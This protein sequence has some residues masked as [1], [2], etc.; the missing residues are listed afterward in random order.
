MHR[1][2][3]S[4][5]SNLLYRCIMTPNN[6][7]VHAPMLAHFLCPNKCTMMHQNALNIQFKPFPSTQR[8]LKRGKVDFRIFVS[9]FSQKYAH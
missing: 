8:P 9:N 4:A 3:Q 1:T 2:D 7:A 6:M 5:Q